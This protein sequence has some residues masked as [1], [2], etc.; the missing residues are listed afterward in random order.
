[1][2]AEFSIS[3]PD[4][5]KIRVIFVLN[6]SVHRRLKSPKVILFGNDMTLERE[7]AGLWYFFSYGTSVTRNS[8]EVAPPP[9]APAR[10]A[11][12]AEIFRTWKAMAES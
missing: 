5:V 12:C 3:P 6:R 2:S 9:I 1:M 4:I 8:R 7:T 10:S 11:L